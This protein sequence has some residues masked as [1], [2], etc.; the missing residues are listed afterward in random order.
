MTS[1]Q[2]CDI[3][4][5]LFGSTGDSG[6]H[7]TDSP[8]RPHSCWTDRCSMHK[9]S[10]EVLAVTYRH[11]S[12]IVRMHRRWETYNPELE[13]SDSL[14]T[15]YQLERL[16]QASRYRPSQNAWHHWA[17]KMGE[18]R[19]PQW[20]LRALRVSPMTGGCGCTLAEGGVVPGAL[21]QTTSTSGFKW[22]LVSSLKL[23]E[24][25]PKEDKRRISGWR[26][27]GWSSAMM[28]CSSRN[29]NP[30]E[31]ARWG[32]RS[33]SQNRKTFHAKKNEGHFVATLSISG[34]N[35]SSIISVSSSHVILLKRYQISRLQVFEGNRDRSSV[36][37]HVLDPPI[38]A[39]FVR[40]HPEAWH[41]HISM[42]AEFYGCT[43]G[44]KG[45]MIISSFLLSLSEGIVHV[46]SVPL[47]YS[48]YCI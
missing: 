26:D 10:R 40:I 34:R 1:L 6:E 43:E 24:S 33:D 31:S 25:R 14:T 9:T 28:E 36:V 16:P 5:L 27:T 44:G 17:F 20:H 45:K 23:D 11:E 4:Y 19:T 30:K 2:V 37:S 18:F 3:T 13:W 39:R 32:M 47:I 29:T 38:V 7:T 21:K 35:L 22:T 15:H 48:R 8:W 42:R 12:G 46:D 41:G